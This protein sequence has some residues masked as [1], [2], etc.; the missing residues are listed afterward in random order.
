MATLKAQIN[1]SHNMSGHIG[2]TGSI[3][4]KFARRGERGYS[5]YDVAVQ[6]GY[7]GTEAEFAAA[8]THLEY[9]PFD[10]RFHFPNIGDVNV[11]YGDTTEN[12][13]YRYAPDD[14]KYYCVG[15]DYNDIIA[16]DGGHA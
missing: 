2:D 11:L 7:T 6:N 9:L 12:K 8:L 4:V 14:G 13:L 1:G 5:A 3:G 10:S 15:S 16:I